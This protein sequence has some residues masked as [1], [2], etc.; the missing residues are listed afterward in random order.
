MSYAPLSSD[1]DTGVLSASIFLESPCLDFGGGLTRTEHLTVHEI[2]HALGAVPACDENPTS[3]HVL[4]ETDVMRHG[5]L[6]GDT[7][8]AIDPGRDE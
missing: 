2:L 1:E 5:R 8:Y 7:A 6:R 4:D 3:T